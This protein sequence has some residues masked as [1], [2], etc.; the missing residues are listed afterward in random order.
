LF[1]PKQEILIGDVVIVLG[2]NSC[3]TFN[4]KNKCIEHYSRT[5]YINNELIWELNDPQTL[6]ID[7]V[8]DSFI[9]EEAKQELVA[10]VEQ[11]NLYLTN[12]PDN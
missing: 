3:L 4:S 10:E 1:R 6:N 5:I 7:Y 11:F 12:F 8:D 9:I 2:N